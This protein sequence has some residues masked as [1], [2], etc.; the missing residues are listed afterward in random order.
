[1]IDK[2][3]KQADKKIHEYLQSFKDEQKVNEFLE[4]HKNVINGIE[5]LT[6]G[7]E[8]T[9]LFYFLIDKFGYLLDTD[10]DKTVSKFGVMARSGTNFL[11]SKFGPNFLG[12]PIVIEN[13]NFLIDPYAIDPSQVKKDKKIKLPKESVIWTANHAFKDDTLA[14]MVAMSRHAYILFGSLPQF[15]NTIDGIL[16]WAI[17]V[18]LTNRKNKESR[19]ASIEKSIQIIK[20]GSDLFIF[21]EGVWNK[22]PNQLLIDLWPGVYRIAKETG[23]KVVPMAHYLRDCTQFNIPNNE[24]HTVIDDPISFDGLS[25]KAALSLLRDSIA[26]WYYLMMEKY[27]KSTYEEE[28]KNYEN[29]TEAWEAHL[30]ARRATVGYYDEEIELC[31]DYRPKDKIR[32]EDVWE[33]IANLHLNDENNEIKKLVKSAK[34]E[35]FQRRF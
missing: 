27:G 10:V 16:A 22:T 13:R 31:A 18:S 14:S 17:G 32:V 7:E 34:L 28:M 35:D 26:T 29:S 4:K 11:I 25:E 1:M 9:E 33:P 19:Q 20:K 21:P 24:I 6:A 15:Y 12:S 23:C 5:D 30:K 8:P 3:K 2:L